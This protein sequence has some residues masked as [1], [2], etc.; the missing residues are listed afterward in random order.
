MKVVLKERIDPLG[1][2]GEIVEVAKGYARN[3]LLPRG[4]AVQATRENIR[5]V[6]SERKA[7]LAREAKRIEDAQE[8]QRAIEKLQITVSMKAN[9]DGH[10]F[11]SVSD[12]VIADALAAEKITIDPKMVR[13]DNPIRELGV[14]DVR[15]HIHP[16]VDAVAKI[17]VVRQKEEESAEEA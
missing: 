9:E 11:G 15:L 1:R 8:I 7:Y 2:R 17:W 3:F 14:Y 4:L 16:E 13:L 12:R 5:Q 10:L 6:E